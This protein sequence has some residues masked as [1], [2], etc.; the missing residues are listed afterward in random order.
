MLVVRYRA[1]LP[2]D[3]DAVLVAV[4]MRA[5]G[6]ARGGRVGQETGRT[7]DRAVEAGRE[8]DRTVVDLHAGD[9]EVVPQRDVVYGD[10]AVEA[11]GQVVRLVRRL[12]DVERAQPRVH[13]VTGLEDLAVRADRGQLRA[14]GRAPGTGP[15]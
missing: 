2:A 1:G 8:T 10:A 13:V 15:D 5:V 12:A 3:R 7:A 11:A 9:G 6:A 14:A 4:H